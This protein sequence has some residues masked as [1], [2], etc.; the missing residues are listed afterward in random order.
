MLKISEFILTEDIG[1]GSTILQISA[2]IVQNKAHASTKWAMLVL[3][4]LTQCATILD[5]MREV[6]G[7]RNEARLTVTMP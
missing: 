5:S 7:Q 6:L 4:R 3:V 2:A 1:R